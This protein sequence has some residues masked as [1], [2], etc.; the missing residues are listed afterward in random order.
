MFKNSIKKREIQ[1]IKIYTKTLH[2]SFAL[3]LHNIHTKVFYKLEEY[4][5]WH[6]KKYKPEKSKH[7]NN[8]LIY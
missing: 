5:N 4:K 2:R 1:S 3:L 7:N 6:F 8:K